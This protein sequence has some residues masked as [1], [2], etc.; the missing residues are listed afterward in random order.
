M[1]QPLV[2]PT[3]P[4]TG[5]II[6][7][8]RGSKRSMH[9]PSLQLL[10][11][12]LDSVQILIH[13]GLSTE[14]SWCDAPQ[15]DTHSTL[16]SQ[17]QLTAE[18]TAGLCPGPSGSLQAPQYQSPSLPP[19]TLLYDESM[20]RDREQRSRGAGELVKPILTYSCVLGAWSNRRGSGL[21]QI[22]QRPEKAAHRLHGHKADFKAPSPTCLS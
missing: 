2:F 5:I 21:T 14:T 9:L 10:P 12:L 13:P 7:G 11:D 6:P 19:A 16:S 3:G 8:A 4:P 15:L 17:E 18:L 20:Y 22:F 1:L